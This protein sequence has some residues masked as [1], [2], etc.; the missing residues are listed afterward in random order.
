MKRIACLWALVL[1]CLYANAQSGQLITSFGSGGA[2]LTP[3]GPGSD[4]ARNLVV[5]SNGK[6]VVVGH[7][8]NGND[9]DFAIARYNTDGS[10]DNSFGTGG[11][12]TTD[13]DGG[14]DLA[15]GVAIQSDGKIVV[16]GDG[17][18]TSYDFT[19]I[20]YL[21]NG[22]L[23]TSF[24]GDGIA[25]VDITGFQSDDHI[26]YMLIQPDGKIV[27]NG[28]R[29]AG[30]NGDFALIRLNT[31]GSPDATF[32]GGD[33]IVYTD[34]NGGSED[35]SS[36]VLLQPDGKLILC[37]S[38]GGGSVYDFAAVRYNANGT[39]DASFGTG[40]GVLYSIG[41]DDHCYA[42]ALQA[43]GKIVLVGWA[44]MSGQDDFGTIR[45]KSNGSLDST[46]GVNG[47]VTTNISPGPSDDQAIG[48][49][50]QPDGKIVLCGNS[51][52]GDFNLVRY[53]TLG[54]PD[55]TFDSDGIATAD[56]SGGQNDFARKVRLAGQVIYV[57]G[58]AQQSGNK[59]F[60][61]A[62]FENDGY[63]LRQVFTQSGPP[64]VQQRIG[65]ADDRAFVRMQVFPNPVVDL[66]QVRL[67][68][69]ITG[70][71]VVQV[72]DGAGKVVRSVDVTA[73]GH[74]LTA[75][76]P[77]GTLSRGA[78]RLRILGGSRPLTSTFL[79]Q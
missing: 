44:D 62:A 60:A 11:F 35:F 23:D 71:L 40:G 63:S 21:A 42:S 24:S 48:V 57:A 49:A 73:S 54:V 28:Y 13:I 7:A 38:S 46:F 66:L 43:D 32:G 52:N 14:D 53:D 10:L 1:I 3:V 16:A 61:L 34:L 12:V 55:S 15:Y 25:T 65:V 17:L 37:G 39:L 75:M 9:L 77:V 69:G 27:A 45:L 56:I 79:K 72:V 20:R 41:G 2:A 26:N 58:W 50:L 68:A 30:S 18:Q 31:N 29:N 5:Q 70:K 47:I 33:G 19:V 8:Y 76:V 36:G 74:G 59:E 51:W 78:Y 64:A 4:E 22:T 67:P 6:I